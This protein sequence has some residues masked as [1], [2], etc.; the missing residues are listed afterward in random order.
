M[1]AFMFYT[2]CRTANGF[3]YK[4]INALRELDDC[5]SC[6][7]YCRPF[8]WQFWQDKLFLVVVHTCQVDYPIAF[9]FWHIMAE[10]F[11]HLSVFWQAAESDVTRVASLI[12]RCSRAQGDS[13][14]FLF[15]DSSLDEFLHEER[16]RSLVLLRRWETKCTTHLVVFKVFWL[17]HRQEWEF[18]TT[19]WSLLV[20]TCK[21]HF[22][23]RQLTFDSFFR[24]L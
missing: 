23:K 10:N 21:H 24:P 5:A 8:S 7:E 13:K 3:Y 19:W 18:Y 12:R 6:V 2:F 16:T 17:M 15:Y 20:L 1:Y 11:V 14:L 9:V 22:V 4:V